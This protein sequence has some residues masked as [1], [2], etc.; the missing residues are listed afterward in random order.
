MSRPS[1]ALCV[2]LEEQPRAVSTSTA[3]KLLVPLNTAVTFHTTDLSWHGY[4][5]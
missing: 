1:I 4:G 2:R 3:R 5:R